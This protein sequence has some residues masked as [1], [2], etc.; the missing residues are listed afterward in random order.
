MSR[1][2]T[3]AR[4]LALAGVVLAGVPLATAPALAGDGMSYGSFKAADVNGNGAVDSREF[5]AMVAR[6]FADLD[7]N[8]DNVL[9]ANESAPLF[10]DPAFASAFAGYRNALP[11]TVY[12]ARLRRDF[13]AADKNHDGVLTGG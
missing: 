8:S 2:R 13:A 3:F 5:E 9:T 11:F 6:T 7:K 10:A 1:T 12:L 4:L